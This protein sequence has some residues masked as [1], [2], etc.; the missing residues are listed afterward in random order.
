MSEQDN[1]AVRYHPSPFRLKGGYAS[2]YSVRD[3]LQKIY[4]LRNS[5]AH[6]FFPENRRE[7]KNVGTVPYS[8]VDIRTPAGLKGFLEDADKAFKYLHARAHG[9]ELGLDD[10]HAS[11]G[12]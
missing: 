1:T 9:P 4:A 6:S 7:F 8:G 2:G 12:L 5:L 11:P 10:A 3:A